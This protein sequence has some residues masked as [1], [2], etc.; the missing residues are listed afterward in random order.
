MLLSTLFLGRNSPGKLFG[1]VPRVSLKNK[2]MKKIWCSRVKRSSRSEALR[3]V[4]TTDF[5]REFDLAQLSDFHVCASLPEFL[6]A[7]KDGNFFFTNFFFTC[8]TDFAEKRE[9]LIAYRLALRHWSPTV[10]TSA[11]HSTNVFLFSRHHIPTNSVAPL[12][13]YRPTQNPLFLRSL[14][15]RANARNVSP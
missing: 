6:T 4:A 13:A 9:L 15:R 3:K 1:K 10:S 11:F 14:W 7:H 2:K 5:V 12:Y 8:T